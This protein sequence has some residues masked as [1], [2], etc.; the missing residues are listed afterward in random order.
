MVEQAREALAHQARWGEARELFTKV[1]EQG[2]NA[3][4]AAARTGLAS[5]DRVSDRPHEALEHLAEV[6]RL[7]AKLPA[8]H[9]FVRKVM[10]EHH[11]ELAKCWLAMGLPDRAEADLRSAAVVVDPGDATT[12]FMI[13][14][15]EVDLAIANSEFAR[16]YSFLA[17]LELPAQESVGSAMS[18]MLSAELQLRRALVELRQVGPAES[19]ASGL[20]RLFE[21]SSLAPGIRGRAGLELLK[22]L[23]LLQKFDQAESVSAGL[24]ELPAENLLRRA[25]AKAAHARLRI[26]R[27]VPISDQVVDQAELAHMVDS[28]FSAWRRQPLRPGGSGRFLYDARRE[29]VATLL[30]LDRRVLPANLASLAACRHLEAALSLGTLTQRLGGSLVDPLLVQR[31]HLP[32]GCGIL[33]YAGGVEDF[34]IIIIDR[35]SINHIAIDCRAGLHDSLMLLCDEIEAQPPMPL[36]GGEQSATKL[37]SRLAAEMLPPAV[38][39]RIQGWRSLILVGEERL[40]LAW[41]ALP[42]GA[43]CIG[44]EFAVSHVPSL[45]L[46]VALEQRRRARP[47]VA[48]G[49]ALAVFADP[50][51]TSQQVERWGVGELRLSAAAR[52]RL[53]A[54]VL[55]AA[56]VSRFGSEVT[57]VALRGDEVARAS[58]WTIVAHGVM[59]YSLERSACILLGGDGDGVLR[60]EEVEAL[61]VPRWIALGVCNAAGG[62]RRIGDDGVHHLGGAFLSAGADAVVLAGGQLAVGATVELLSHFN[63][64]VCSG[65]APAEALRAARAAVRAMRGRSHPYFHASMRLSGLG[66][67]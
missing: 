63:A 38:A 54:G 49:S 52:K 2:P 30:A 3:Y 20:E 1:L 50:A 34:H 33:M 42:W 29:L 60:V 17:R 18:R 10:A 66:Q 19:T 4:R 16:A 47:A 48:E 24:L 57:P 8:G 55:P 13:G 6:P 21:D 35:E 44:T 28:L 27:E 7:L 46:L 53:C 26:H 61:R 37:T 14:I 12:R 56:L 59:D 65:K 31:D 9:A 5:L 62:P 11:A 15:A 43:G 45:S 25:E 67:R 23:R 51:L 32:Q 39:A 58:L 41:Q 22:Q 40:A 36:D 64:A